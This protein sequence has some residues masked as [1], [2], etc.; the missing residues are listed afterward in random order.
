MSKKTKATVAIL[1]AVAI[2]IGIFYSSSM[3]Y[4][5]QSLVLHIQHLLPNQPFAN[6]LSKIQFEYAGKII[7][8]PSLGYAEFIEFFIRKGAHFFIYFLLGTLWAK[9]LAV[10][11]KHKGLA[12]LTALLITTCYAATDEFHQGLV[13]GR[14]SLIQDV[15]LDSAGGLLGVI[16]GAFNKIK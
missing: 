8:I 14:T 10:H 1:V 12:Y 7:S 5:S 11:V 6:E 2:M 15:L 9:G 4:K 16:H 3:S 13:V